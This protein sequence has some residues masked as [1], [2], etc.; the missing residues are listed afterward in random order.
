MSNPEIVID[1]N[2]LVSGLRSREGASYRLL[3]LLGRGRF[4]VNVSVPLVLE[5]E[6]VLLRPGTGIPLPPVAVDDVLDYICSIARHHRIFFLWR[7]FLKDPQDDMLLELAVKSNSTW[8]VTF[9]TRDF[10]GCERFG[11]RAAA[12]AEFLRSIGALR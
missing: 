11:V 3:S 6:D 7:P 12:P 5:Y 8:I 1:T 4:H 9:N 2:V 10:V